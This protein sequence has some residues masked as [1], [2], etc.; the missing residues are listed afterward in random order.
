MAIGI[1][2]LVGYISQ[3]PSQPQLQ[4]K[5]QERLQPNVSK[6]T[7]A[8]GVEYEFLPPDSGWFRPINPAHWEIKDNYVY[9]TR[10]ETGKTRIDFSFRFPRGNYE[11]IKL[12]LLHLYQ[13]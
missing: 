11:K 8:E 1:L 3:K 7:T 10:T 5:L 12:I 4:P 9:V 2:L 13:S 6:L